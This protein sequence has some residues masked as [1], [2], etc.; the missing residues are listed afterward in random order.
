M[1]STEYTLKKE[2]LICAICVE[3]WL[4]KDSRTLPCQHTFC[5][6]CLQQL[7]GGFNL[8]CPICRRQI[9]I[10][11]R[12]VGNFPK[13]FL[14]NAIEKVT[15]DGGLCSVHGKR[16]FQPL[17]CCKS[18]QSVN[19]CNVCIENDHSQSDCNIVTQ[20]LLEN[21]YTRLKDSFK[22]R[23]EKQKEKDGRAEYLILSEIEK[24][25]NIFNSK[26]EHYFDEKKQQVKTF[27]KE[28][29]SKLLLNP[30]ENN[31]L[32][33]DHH[34]LENKLR[35]LFSEQLPIMD[36]PKF[37]YKNEMEFDLNKHIK[38]SGNMSLSKSKE[39]RFI[40]KDTSSFW[41]GSDGIY[42]TLNSQLNIIKFRSTFN[43]LTKDIFLDRFITSF[44]VTENYIYVIDATSSF[45]FFAKKPFEYRINFELFSLTTAN[46]IMAIEDALDQRYLMSFCENTNE[47]KFFINDKYEWSAFDC[48]SLGCILSNGYP[49]VQTD[50][51]NVVL[52]DKY[53]GSVIKSLRLKGFSSIYD[54]SPFGILVSVTDENDISSILHLF[55]YNLKLLKTINRYKRA[56]VLG[57]TKDCNV[58]IYFNDDKLV[59]YDF[60]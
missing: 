15:V 4:D 28:R 27:F 7:Q 35:K 40:L 12:D 46:K 43:P 3:S 26:I 54:L 10:P 2:E 19:L 47:C 20:S 57:S 48:F 6:K 14:L 55:D 22:N 25:Q 59:H 34:T 33:M 52:L 53:N 56:F 32:F 13:N 9:H 23:V 45:I 24:I 11:E 18:C 44:V 38:P 60:K 29:N 58:C 17:L 16:K 30:E 51:Y 39:S 50:I 36:V 41:V 21:G 5:L 37:E 8:E 42:F 49:I 1:A 31:N